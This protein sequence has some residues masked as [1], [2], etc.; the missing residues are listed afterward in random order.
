MTWTQLLQRN[1]VQRYRGAFEALPL[2]MGSTVAS[3]AA[4]FDTCR[5]KRNAA[6]YD[7]AGLVSESEVEDLI[8]EATRFEQN[9]EDWI[10]KNHPQFAS[11]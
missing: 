4:Y 5:Q 1:R 8:Q 11:P 10:K 9:L 6:T 3:Q 7:Q 2:A